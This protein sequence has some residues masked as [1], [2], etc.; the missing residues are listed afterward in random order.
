MKVNPP[1]QLLLFTVAL[2]NANKCTLSTKLVTLFT[3]LYVDNTDPV[4]LF[5]HL[6]T[7]V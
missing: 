2:Y 7:L 6:H 5:T 3:N 4:F 1:N